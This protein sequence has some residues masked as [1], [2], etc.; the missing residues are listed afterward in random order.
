MLA[1]LR[2]G[3][4]QTI[5]RTAALNEKLQIKRSASPSHSILISGQPVPAL[6]QAPGSI[7]TGLPVFKSL[8]RL[9]PENPGANGIRTQDLRLSRRTPEPTRQTKWS[10][11]S[12]L[13]IDTFV[14]SPPDARCYYVS[15][16][17]GWP[18][19]NI[20]RLGEIASLIGNFCRSV[21]PRTIVLEI[22]Q[23][24]AGA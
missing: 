15:V 7:A 19:V 17:T 21:A 10:H 18:G 1:H 6:T 9:D 2:D 13:K 20:Q 14:V 24:V 5:L 11:I 22:H 23:H 8:V 3:S 16:N 12:D 4:A